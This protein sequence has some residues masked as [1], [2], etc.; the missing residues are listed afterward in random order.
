MCWQLLGYKVVYY[1]KNRGTYQ[2]QSVFL[3]NIDTPPHNSAQEEEGNRISRIEKIKEFI[4]KVN[5]TFA[6]YGK[7]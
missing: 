7:N 1:S 5:E 4:R 2:K 6:N 3:P